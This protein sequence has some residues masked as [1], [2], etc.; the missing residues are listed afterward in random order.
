M[1]RINDLVD[2]NKIF[3]DKITKLNNDVL[4]RRTA[5]SSWQSAPS[6]LRHA[7]EAAYN[8]S[9]LKADMIKDALNDITNLKSIIGY[10]SES[11]KTINPSEIQLHME[12]INNLLLNYI[13]MKTVFLANHGK[14][15]S[16]EFTL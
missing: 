8:D 5:L 6:E 1:D 9:V 7:A 12:N 10:I 11:F 13:S 15:L 2:E 14:L 3:F 16:A 4:F